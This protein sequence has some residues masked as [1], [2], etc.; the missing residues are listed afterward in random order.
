MKNPKYKLIR[1]G[2]IPIQRHNYTARFYRIQAL[3]DIPEHGVKA[4]DLGG[5]VT[6]KRS[7]S[8][9]GSC[10]IAD[11]AKV[12]GKVIIRDNAYIAEQAI[13]I[14]AAASGLSSYNLEISGNARITGSSVVSSYRLV[15]TDPH[16]TSSIKGDVQIYGMALVRNAHEI[17]DNVKIYGNAS[18]TNSSLISGNAEIFGD[19]TIASV[20][21]ISGN[22]KIFESSKIE[23]GVEIVNSVIAGSTHIMPNQR[24]IDGKFNE[25]K[26]G[27][28]VESL[29][30]SSGTT[31][32]DPSSVSDVPALTA[33]PS[34]A[35]LKALKEVEEKIASYETDIVKIIKYPVM[36][37]RT[38]S[39]TQEMI[40]ALNVANRF[41]DNIE[42]NEFKNAVITL[43]KSFLA[44]ESNALKI[45][46]TNLSETDR[47]K[48]ET[49]KNL[50]AVAS[51]EGS[52]EHEKKV[53]FKQA[54]KQLEGVLVVPEIAVD[55][56]R[57]KIGLQELESL[58]SFQEEGSK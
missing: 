45:A 6:W 8:H 17:L 14:K 32:V 38:N 31:Q 47:K 57:V 35:S 41:I 56:F 54:F 20:Q 26:I 33:S 4:G 27:S 46:L 37:D 49:A 15:T 24:V 2:K 1:A 50:L 44:A 23:D 21:K 10:W 52:T 18:V 29:V 48:T 16:R 36:T 3:R 51:N 58:D 11:D 40:F 7:L 19:T 28:T 22:T 34:N 43:E 5:Y 9:D 39:F 12:I 42:S 30:T 13:L 25:T 53:S 55:T